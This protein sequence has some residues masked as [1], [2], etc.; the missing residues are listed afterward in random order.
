MTVMNKINR[1]GL[2]LPHHT[3]RQGFPNSYP[4]GGG[5]A[6]TTLKMWYDLSHAYWQGLEK[7]LVEKLLR[8]LS[9]LR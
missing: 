9:M 1:T 2:I 3:F 5:G 8:C 6:P 7:D 4:V